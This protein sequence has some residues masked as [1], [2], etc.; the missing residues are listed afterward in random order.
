MAGQSIPVKPEDLYLVGD[1][2][3]QNMDE[4]ISIEEQKNRKIMMLLLKVKNGAPPM[5]KSA[6]RQLT[7]NAKE[8]GAGSMY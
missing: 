4:E 8:F 5:R 2:M 7:L 6:L 1:I 3:N